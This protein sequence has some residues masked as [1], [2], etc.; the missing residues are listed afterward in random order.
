MEGKQKMSEGRAERVTETLDTVPKCPSQSQNSVPI[1]FPS[2]TQLEEWDLKSK[3]DLDHLS[4]HWISSQC[5][6]LET[7]SSCLCEQ[8]DVFLND[9]PGLK[10][11]W[12]HLLVPSIYCP[13]L[14]AATTTSHDRYHTTMTIW[15]LQY[16][17]FILSMAELKITK[18]IL[19]TCL[20]GRGGRAQSSLSEKGPGLRLLPLSSFVRKD[21]HSAISWDLNHWHFLQNVSTLLP[22]DQKN[23]QACLPDSPFPSLK[24]LSKQ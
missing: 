17:I 5:L 1:P 20:G 15:V 2:P 11:S 19:W 22:D 10:L 4:N 23:V 6:A 24:L 16:I 21:R 9:N 18:K 12:T 7:V 13:S 3:N 14:A 8:C